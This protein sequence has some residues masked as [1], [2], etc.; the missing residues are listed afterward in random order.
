MSMLIGAVAGMAIKSQKIDDAYE[1]SKENEQSIHELR[2]I[3][4]RIDE[5]LKFIRT[6]I[7][8]MKNG[9]KH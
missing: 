3:M 6:Q 2:E 7:E 4:I 1:C 5:N 8:D 9:K